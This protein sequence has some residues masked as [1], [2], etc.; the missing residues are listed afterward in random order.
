MWL[1]CDLDKKICD[2]GVEIC[3]V[4]KTGNLRYAEWCDIS[5]SSEA[6]SQEANKPRPRDYTFREWTLIKVGHTDI[7]E[8]V[9]K[10]LLKLWLIEC[11]Q[12]NSACENN[13]TH[14]SFDD[15]KWEFNLEINK[16]AD[17][18][19][20]GIGKKGHILDHNPEA[21][22]QFSRPAQSIIIGN[23]AKI[24]ASNH[25]SYD[26]TDIRQKDEKSSKN[27]Q[28]RARNGKA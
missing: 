1:S 9:K 10:A 3:G 23:L 15:Y 21:K 18:Y 2:G 7:S 11:F 28:N 20:L 26:E 24:V 12:G 4:S 5:P 22:R 6:S 13:P 8:P 27:R 16:L 25:Y 17:D 19:E 14:R